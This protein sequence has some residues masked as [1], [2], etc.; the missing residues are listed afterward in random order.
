MS[1]VATAI[2]G[3]AVIGGVTSYLGAQEQSSAAQQAGQTQA[4]ANRYAADIQYKMWQEQQ[5]LQ[6]PWLEAG[7]R[8]LPRVEAQANAM[9]AAFSGKVN[10]LADPGY[11]FRLAEGQKALERSAAARGGL[12]SGGALKAAE[13]YGQDYASQEY[14]NAYN[15]AL[16]EYNA[17][18]QREQT[19]YNRL[20][21]L[22][23]IGQQTAQQLGQAGQ[24]YGQSAA[25]LASATGASSA[26]SLLAQGQARA[27]AYG[28]IG[29]ALGQGVG[30]YM[31]YTQN[32]ALI[33]ALGKGA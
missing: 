8:A 27:S 16:T 23:G 31:N 29:S 32:Q 4:D 24:Q 6:K 28:G 1:G 22:A 15:R 17:A 26:N 20:S 5:A 10:M 30:A 25:G 9:P 33:N 2:A 11:A 7:Q 12:I 3:A 18:V 19:G 14:Q 21:G 13:R